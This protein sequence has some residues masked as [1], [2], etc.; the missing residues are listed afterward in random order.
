MYKSL[1]IAASSVSSSMA[2]SGGYSL[3]RNIF[4][5]V[6]VPPPAA[7]SYHIH[8]V[9]DLSDSTSLPAAKALRELSREQFSDLLGPDCDGRY[10]NARLCLIFDHNIE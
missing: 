5:S 4:G 2:H 10:D 3:P 7:L 9:F 1:L 6:P 8:I